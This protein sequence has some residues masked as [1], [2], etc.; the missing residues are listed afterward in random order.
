MSPGKPAYYV[1]LFPVTTALGFYSVRSHINL[2]K[3]WETGKVL[4][5]SEG[6]FKEKTQPT[7]YNCE[8]FNFMVAW[9]YLCFGSMFLRKLDW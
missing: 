5:F 9:T 8:L 6:V 3:W 2:D 7:I 1:Q 4:D